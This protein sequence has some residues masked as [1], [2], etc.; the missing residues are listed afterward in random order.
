MFGFNTQHSQ[1]CHIVLLVGDE[2]TLFIN[3]NFK[4]FLPHEATDIQIENLKYTFV[5]FMKKS[6]V[7]VSSKNQNCVCVFVSSGWALCSDGKL[8]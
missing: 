2:R 1:I 4:T 8:Q 6:H 5:K 3:P 7:T